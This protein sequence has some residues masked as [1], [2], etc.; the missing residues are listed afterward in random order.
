MLGAG[1][2]AVG[3]VAG[4]LAHGF[5]GLQQDGAMGALK[6]LGRGA[7]YGIPDGAGWA[8]KMSPLN[9]R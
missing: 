2:G 3:S 7:L 9:R 8:L 5:K 4:P 6:G 1:G